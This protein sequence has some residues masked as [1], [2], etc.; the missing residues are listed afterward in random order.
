[1]ARTVLWHRDE[2]AAGYIELVHDPQLWETY[3]AEFQKTHGLL[4]NPLLALM[5]WR[6]AKLAAEN[7]RLNATAATDG[8]YLYSQVNLG[9]TVQAGTSL[10]VVVVH[11]AASKSEAEFV[12]NLSDLQRAAMKRALKAG[13]TAGATIGFTSMARWNNVARHIPIL[14]PQTSLMLAHSSKINGLTYLGASYG[15]TVCS[16]GSTSRRRCRHYRF[17]RLK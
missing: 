1:M 17:Y 13:Q 9:F 2:A 4:L 10:Y 3:A 5:A 12:R 7:P 14:I 16:R 8:A 6:L 15:T 11:D